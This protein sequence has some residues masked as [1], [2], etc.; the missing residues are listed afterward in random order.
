[1]YVPSEFSPSDPGI[2]TAVSLAPSWF[3]STPGP[4]T[5][6][7]GRDQAVWPMRGRRAHWEGGLKCQFT[8]ISILSELPQNPHGLHFTYS[9]FFSPPTCF[10]RKITLKKPIFSVFSLPS[11]VL[12]SPW[13]SCF[14]GSPEVKSLF[15]TSSASQSFHISLKWGR[16]YIL[17]TALIIYSELFE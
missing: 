3:Q 9:T 4:A 10:C 15:C 2:R 11:S 1:M 14:G 16:F 5:G 6:K 17:S 8:L 12:G 13:L 7:V